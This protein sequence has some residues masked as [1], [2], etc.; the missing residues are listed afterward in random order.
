MKPGA[1]EKFEITREQILATYAAGPDA[2]VALI[3]RMSATIEKLSMIVEQQEQRIKALEEELRKDSHNSGKPPSRDSFERKQVQREKPR[4]ARK[5][6]PGGQKGHRGTTLQMVSTPDIIRVHEVD[7]CGCG[8]SLRTEAVVGYERRQ[9]FDIPEVQVQVTEHCAERRRCQRCGVISAGEFPAGVAQQ[10]QYGGRLQAYAVYLRN[11]GL[12]PYHRLAELFEDLFSIPLSP[13]TLVNIN[14]AC[15]QRLAG[16]SQAIRTAL[17]GE[18]VICCDETGMSIGGTLNW[19]HVTSTESLTYYAAHRKRGQQAL[20]AID[21]LPHFQ[22]TAM[23]DHWKSYFRYKCY[24][25]LCN[26]HHLRELTFIH[27]EYGQ[28][29]AKELY[30]LLLKINAAPETAVREGRVRLYQRIRKGFASQYRRIICAGL[31]ANPPP[32]PPAGGVK[33]HG[34]RKQSKPRNLLLRLA[35]RRRETL[36]FM[37]DFRVPFT[38]NQ[39]ERDLRMMKVQQ[40]ISGAFRS[41]DAA[42]AFCQIRGYIAT[43]RKNG[44]RVIDALQSAFLGQPTIPSCLSPPAE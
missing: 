29:W 28:S 36:A 16:V 35:T 6:K 9:V 1:D 12:L 39:A 5:K 8:Q 17:I 10:V 3:E 19:L 34:R 26:A 27:E 30:D 33:K 22:G 18:P 21:I 2:I 44:L 23:H 25:A 42:A 43:I 11:Y 20:A 40:K 38:N 31:R 24:H 41:A 7:C 14:G 32:P 15:G 13:A 4:S 37:Y